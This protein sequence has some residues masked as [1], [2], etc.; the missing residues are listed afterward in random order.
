[1]I[2]GNINFPIDFRNDIYNIWLNKCQELNVDLTLVEQHNW[3]D[4]FLANQE[5]EKV[6]F[7]VWYDSKGFFTK[8]EVLENTSKPLISKIKEICIGITE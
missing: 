1:M 3:Q 2:N 6:K 7:R 4:I 8:I 5:K